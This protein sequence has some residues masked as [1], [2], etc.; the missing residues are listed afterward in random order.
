M[1]YSAT[2]L[3]DPDAGVLV[4]QLLEAPVGVLPVDELVPVFP[5]EAVDALLELG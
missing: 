2:Y 1:I 5:S 3:Q 4:R